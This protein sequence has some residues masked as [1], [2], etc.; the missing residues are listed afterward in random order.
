[1]ALSADTKRVFE[2]GEQTTVPVK[3]SAQI[4]IGSAVGFTSG[5]ARSL[6]AGD[7]FAGFALE[8][9]LG[10]TDGAVTCQVS[11][12]GQVS[13]AITSIAVTDIGKPVYASD[14]GTFTLTQGSN[15]KIGTVSRWVATG[16]AIVRYQAQGAGADFSGVTVLTDSTGAT[17][18]NTIA[19]VTPAATITDNSG[20]VDP[21][22]NTIAVVTAPGAAAAATAV[23]SA[24]LT[25][26]TLTDNGG[27]AAADGTIADIA[28]ADASET[29]DRSVIADA[30]KELSDQINKLIVDIGAQKS[31]QDKL[32]TDHANYITKQAANTAAVTALSAAVAQLAA[33]QNTTST[34]I[35]AIENSLSDLATKINELINA[36]S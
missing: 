5:Y 30:I 18:D 33:K 28:S 21:G 26:A 24:A 1:M 10:T 36:A 29:T 13:L 31:E 32:V 4:Y 20:G 35:T 12:H 19:N 8:N 7:D 17:P 25:A 11:T 27:G 15:S 16:T 23:T 9:K 6:T 22:D 3:A 34:A 2:L 14:D